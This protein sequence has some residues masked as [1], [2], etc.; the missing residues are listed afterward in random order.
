MGG[1]V[2]FGIELAVGRGLEDGI[3]GRHGHEDVIARSIEEGA[4]RGETSVGGELQ[5]SLDETHWD[6]SCSAE[7]IREGKKRRRR[8]EVEVEVK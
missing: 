7:L 3:R 2:L 6:V 5:E 8:R 4:R 1:G